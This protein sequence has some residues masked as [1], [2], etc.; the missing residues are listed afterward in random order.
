MAVNNCKDKT[1]DL[2]IGPIEK[3]VTEGTTRKTKAS[4]EVTK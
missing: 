4:D 1:K 3:S 2:F